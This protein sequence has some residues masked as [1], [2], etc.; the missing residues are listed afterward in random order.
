MWD[1]VGIVRSTKRLERAR[2]RVDLLHKEI[3]E[4]Y[5]NFRI[6]GDLIEL[7][8]LVQV[9][10]LIIRSALKRKESRGLHYTL[11]YLDRDDK[12][13]RQTSPL[14]PVEYRPARPF[15]T[16]LSLPHSRNNTECNRLSA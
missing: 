16:Y 11:D 4:F 8:N 3:S 14:R 1:Y 7:R 10:K 6:T 15:S 9:A 13:P 5:G 2:N 12:W